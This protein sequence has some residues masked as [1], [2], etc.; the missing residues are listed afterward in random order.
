MKAILILALLLTSTP[1]LAFYTECSATKDMGLATRPDGPT[2]P[3][4]Q[5]IEK[6]DKLAF[7]NSYKDWWFVLPYK[8]D[9]T[10]YGWVPRNALTDCQ[11]QEG[12]P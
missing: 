11:R 1:A 6:G 4:Y 2:E 10:E 9:T 12:T 5:R 8:G 3:R 7:R